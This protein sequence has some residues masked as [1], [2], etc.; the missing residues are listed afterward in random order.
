MSSESI[1]IHHT[2][3]KSNGSSTILFNVDDLQARVK[4]IVSTD[5]GKIQITLESEALDELSIT[6]AKNLLQLQQGMVMVS[7]KPQQMDLF[8]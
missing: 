8:Q 1:H 6:K 2:K 7:I 3:A 4:R 5:E